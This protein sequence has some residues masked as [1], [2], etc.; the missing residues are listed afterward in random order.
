MIE[1][2]EV[3]DA[4][5]V[6]APRCGDQVG[7]DGLLDRLVLDGRLDDQIGLGRLGQ[8][9]RRRRCVARAASALGLVDRAACSTWRARLARDG[10]QGLRQR[11][12]AATSYSRTS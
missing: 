3:L 2:D 1:I 7:E 10:A 8:G 5:R 12:R 9:R 4:S 6:S 11:D